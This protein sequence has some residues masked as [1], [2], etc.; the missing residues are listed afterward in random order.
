MGLAEEWGK[1]KQACADTGQGKAQVIGW[2]RIVE[3]TRLGDIAAERA[4]A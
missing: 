3:L 2:A 4:E 1:I